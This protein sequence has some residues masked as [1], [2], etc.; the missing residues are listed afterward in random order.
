MG[1]VGDVG[2]G[3]GADRT[4]PPHHRLHHD[5]CLSSSITFLSFHKAPLGKDRSAAAVSTLKESVRQ[6]QREI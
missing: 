6:R 1:G 2:E 5:L 3:G 4:W